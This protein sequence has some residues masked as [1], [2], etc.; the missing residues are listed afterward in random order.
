MD[1]VPHAEL[2]YPGDGFYYHDGKRF[3]GVGYLLN[4]EGGWV[5]AETE[6]QNGLPSGMKREWAAP[7]QLLYEAQ[8]RGGVVHGRKR[9][10]G[11]DGTLVEDGE[12][13]YG[14]PLWE[15]MWDEDGNL[16]DDYKLEKK[17]ANYQL[18]EKYRQLE[19]DQAAQRKRQP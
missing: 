5:E 1:R 8:F 14:I 10:W 16:I 17:D 12:Y 13:E 19:K 7:G 18:L 6:Y 9:R 11:D 15:K 2:D 4:T 3:T